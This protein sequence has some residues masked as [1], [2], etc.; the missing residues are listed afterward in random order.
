MEKSQQNISH[1]FE[2]KK[3]EDWLKVTL[4]L[5]TVIPGKAQLSKSNNRINI[6]FAESWR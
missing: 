1:F 4:K 6:R 5:E 3:S 2:R